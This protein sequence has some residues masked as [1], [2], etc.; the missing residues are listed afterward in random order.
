MNLSAST[1]PI[2]RRWVLHSYYTL[3]PWAPDGS[4]RL[5]LSGGDPKTNEGEVVVL[6]SDGEV[7][8]RMGPVPL[9]ESYWHTG[10]W[11]TWG[12]DA[13]S[14]Y[15][16]DGSLRKPVIVRHDL[17]T[18]NAFRQEGGL[19]GSPPHGEP[20]I[21]ALLGMLYGAGYG[22][23]VYNKDLFPI[24]IQQ[25][26]RHG[27]FRY[28]FEPSEQSLMLSVQD[29]IDSHPQADRLRREDE[30]IGLRLG[31]GERL[32][33]MLYCVRWNRQGTRCL[34]FF[35]NHCVVGERGEP[36]VA[37]VMTADRE[38]KE[39]HLAVDISFDRRGVHWGWQPD[40][41]HLVGYGP[42][43][44]GKGMC[45]AGVRYDGTNYRKLST[46]RS[47]GHPSICPADSRLA[48]T[49]E[50]SISGRV[51]FIDVENDREIASCSPGRV[52]GDSEPPG[53]NPFRVCHHPVF[54]PDGRR[55]LVNTLNRSE[56]GPLAQVA[57][58][59]AEPVIAELRG[60]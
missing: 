38:F 25:R 50:S 4:G 36:R 43:P 14:I 27:L 53:R 55:V 49:D 37:Y 18:G 40:G 28:R 32:T 17:E 3:C 19:E 7:E 56:D 29:V 31:E 9:T 8:H 23:G 58:I 10:F 21:S 1:L 39:I 59:D 45:L 57:V 2:P 11:Q 30:A 22:T 52:F 26:D 51:V 5:L 48:V 35:G 13:T 44:E 15:Y 60:K 6:S 42:N 47:G 24:P 33:L 16:Q 54:S 41:E 34:F 20:I 46:H 12:P